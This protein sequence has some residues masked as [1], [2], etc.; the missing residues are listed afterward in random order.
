MKVSTV[1]KSVEVTTDHLIQIKEHPQK[2][3]LSGFDL[4]GKNIGVSKEFNGTK[5]L[6]EGLL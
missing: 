6:D 2:E 4:S 3:N 1:Q 5:A